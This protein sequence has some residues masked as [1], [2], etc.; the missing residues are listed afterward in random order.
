ML[1]RSYVNAGR[2]ASNREANVGDNRLQININVKPNVMNKTLK[3][4]VDALYKGQGSKGQIGNGTTMDA[5]RN[6][7]KTGET[8]IDT[9]HS[10]KA[11]KMHKGLENV[12]RSGKLNEHEKAVARL[13]RD[14]IKKA[15]SE[16]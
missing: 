11:R 5:V 4:I 10:K 9:F 13:L 8:T 15:L 3:N 16:N 12:L 1:I 14:D 6:E 2:S 7:R